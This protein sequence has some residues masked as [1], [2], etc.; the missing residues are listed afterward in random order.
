MKDTIKRLREL[1]AEATPGPWNCAI[2]NTSEGYIDLL[3]TGN[4]RIPSKDVDLDLIDEMRN[5]I[6]P[7]LDRLEKL[8]AAVEAGRRL[9]ESAIT[10]ADI[11]ADGSI[12]PTK[13]SVDPEEFDKF[14]DVLSA[15][16]EE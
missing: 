6:K 8:E 13:C 14:Q 7:L 2:G 3:P 11:L 5:S 16:E 1:E 10:Q 9:V 12:I 4:E 15:L